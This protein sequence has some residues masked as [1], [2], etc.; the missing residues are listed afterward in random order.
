M[1][2]TGAQVRGIAHVELATA[3][4]DAAIDYFADG[5]GFTTEPMI[6]SAPDRRCVLL[7]QGG[8]RLVVSSPTTVTGEIAEYVDR[9]GDGV[10]DIAFSVDDAGR[11]YAAALARGASPVREPAR[12]PATGGGVTTTA[13]VRGTG[14]LLHTFVSGG[15]AP[16]NSGALLQ[17]VDHAAICLPAGT[18][19]QT[20]DFYRTV[21]GL[22]S[23]FTERIEVGEQAMNSEVVQNDTGEVTFTLIEPDTSAKPGQIDAFLA[24][25][26]GA[27]VQHL[28]FLTDD[29]GDAVRAL[30]ERSV[31]FLDAPR[32]YYAA[33]S[34]RLPE[35]A[36]EVHR[37]QELDVLV[38]RDHWGHLL[39]IFTKSVHP[40]GTL[41]FELIERRAART[42]GSGNIR[43]LYEAVEQE[44]LTSAADRR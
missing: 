28:A 39:Q 27:G 9:H 18:L 23:I 20:V 30:R 29:I 3:D 5:M 14:D 13:T 41:F 4:P 38:D 6:G 10:A 22:H 21:F 12:R 36:A 33:L 1:T 15:A 8:I 2:G 7:R 34:G 32:H 19:K 31:R 25:H 24:G 16:T 35:F 40:A 17:L 11:A 43:A 26:G 44:L 37:L 42:F